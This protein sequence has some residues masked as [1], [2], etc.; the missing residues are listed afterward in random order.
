[1]FNFFF[2]HI[3]YSPNCKQC[4]YAI[5][6][7]FSALSRIGVSLSVSGALWTNDT[8]DRPYVTQL[9]PVLFSLEILQL[10]QNNAHWDR[11]KKYEQHLEKEKKNY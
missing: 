3:A 11:D 4:M 8:R 7:S 1:M 9:C 10:I 5:C 6:A 2:S